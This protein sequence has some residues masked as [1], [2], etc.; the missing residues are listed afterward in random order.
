LRTAAFFVAVAKIATVYQ[1]M[2][3]QLEFNEPSACFYD[4]AW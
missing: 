2:D 3:V 4:I 1:Q